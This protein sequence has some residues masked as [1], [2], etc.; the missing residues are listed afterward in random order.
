MKQNAQRFRQV[1]T[2]SN[3][4]SAKASPQTRPD[5][6][7]RF[8]VGRRS[9]RREVATTSTVAPSASHCQSMTSRNG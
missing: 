9:R 4:A 3:T 6:R 1:R 7:L 8:D 2:P 5:S